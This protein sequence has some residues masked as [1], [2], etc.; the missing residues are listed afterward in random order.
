MRAYLD[1]ATAAPPDARVHAAM[2]P[3]LGDAFGSPASLH[4]WAERP[5]LAVEEA[6]A[7]VA[8]LVGAEV[9]EVIFTA[10]ATES[11]NL[12][13]KGLVG[14]NRALGGGIVTTAVEHPATL[15]ACRTLERA[16]HRLAVVGVDGEGRVDP[17]ALAAAVDD[18]TALVTIHHGQGEIG[19][20]QDVAALVAAVRARRPE[21]RVH[22]DAGETAGLLALD[23]AALDVD[24]LTIGGWPVGAPPWT[25]ALVVREGAR[26][27][28]LIEGGVQER[29]KRAGAECV[30]AIA[31]LGEAARLA[32]GEMEWRA[33]R[34]RSLGERLADGLL[35]LP[36][37]RLNGPRR[38]RIPGHVQVSTGTVEG[39]SLALALAAR[40]VACA[41]GSACTAH[42]GKAAPTLEAVGMEAPW[43]HTAVLFTA[44]PHTR[45]GEVDY[46]LEVVEEELARLRAISPLAG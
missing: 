39:E 4:G 14:A 28:P 33:E 18:E 46:A 35:A 43:T 40:G 37:V 19:T 26:L 36:D 34:M 44:G 20:V 2:A 16:G 45:A 29:G 10:G 1:H 32:A 23:V 30:P 38:G 13:I 3:F 6:R 15:A 24:A 5:A 25:G 31:G 8:A 12:A 21:A 17:D 41:P 42:G 27:H 22:L 7:H 11:R 9:D